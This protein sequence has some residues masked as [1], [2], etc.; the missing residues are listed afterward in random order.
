MYCEA[1]TVRGVKQQL[2]GPGLTR[3]MVSLMAAAQVQLRIMA[4]KCIFFSLYEITSITIQFHAGA[5]N[6]LA[7]TS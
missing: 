1:Q 4:Y 3:A 2:Q 7:D 6:S 5:A